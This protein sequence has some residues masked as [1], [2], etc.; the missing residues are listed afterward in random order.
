MKNMYRI[1]R[2]HDY[3][4]ECTTCHFYY[5]E[6]HLSIRDVSRE[7]LLSPATVKRRLEALQDIDADMYDEFIHE[8]SK[9]HA[10]RKPRYNK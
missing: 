4:L 5:V 6:Q 7:T 9:R 3:L 10:G 2:V 1:D 8:R